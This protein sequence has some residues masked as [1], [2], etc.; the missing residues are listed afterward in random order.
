MSDKEVR[1][2]KIPLYKFI[3]ELIHVYDMGIDYIDIVG[4][5][6]DEQDS[7]GILPSEGEEQKERVE[8]IDKTKQKP[9]DLNDLI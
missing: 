1:L 8:D 6:D 3:Q 2:T 7:I 5:T 9:T 4:S